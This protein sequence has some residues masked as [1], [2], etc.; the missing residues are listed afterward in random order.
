M[1]VLEVMEN[2]GI[3]IWNLVLL[4]GIVEVLGEFCLC[5]YIVMGFKRGERVEMDFWVEY[6]MIFEDVFENWLIIMVWVEYCLVLWFDDEVVLEV[7]EVVMDVFYLGILN[8]C[9][10]SEFREE[11]E[12]LLFIVKFFGM[13]DVMMK[14]CFFVEKLVDFL[15]MLVEKMIGEV[16]KLDW[17]FCFIIF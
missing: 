2:D 4:D 5:F 10:C 1:C 12:G 14:G 9:K 17:W 3:E 13:L 6:W 15:W 7:V 8:Y 16:V 11:L